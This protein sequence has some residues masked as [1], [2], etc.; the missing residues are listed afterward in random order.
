MLL[1]FFLKSIK[2]LINR[3][4]K[5]SLIFKYDKRK[6]KKVGP[7]ATLLIEHLTEE[8]NGSITAAQLDGPPIDGDIF[9]PAASVS[10]IQTTIRCL[11]D[12]KNTKSISTPQL[13]IKSFSRIFLL[14][15]LKTFHFWN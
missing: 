7:L 12:A 13:K 4:Q 11:F 6:T 15:Y 10:C 5:D 1:I 9:V 3:H 14:F 2:K 8:T